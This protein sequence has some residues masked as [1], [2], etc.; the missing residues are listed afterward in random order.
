M[1]L[2]RPWAKEAQQVVSPEPDEAQS[3][4]EGDAYEADSMAAKR[5][6]RR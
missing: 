1:R 2:A 6:K 4:R 3:S 5:R